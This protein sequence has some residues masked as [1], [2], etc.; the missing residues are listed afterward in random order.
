MALTRVFRLFLIPNKSL[1]K[2][3]DPP[4][5]QKKK[6]KKKLA[7]FPTQKIAE[8]K[9]SIPRNSIDHSCNLKSGV[10]PPPLGSHLSWFHYKIWRIVLYTLQKLSLPDKA[11]FHMAIYLANKIMSTRHCLYC[12]CLKPYVSTEVN[13]RTL[14]CV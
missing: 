1:L 5:T 3:S 7:N 11:V 6:K 4:P 2:S 14:P 8:S 10:P 9:I 12:W 13:E